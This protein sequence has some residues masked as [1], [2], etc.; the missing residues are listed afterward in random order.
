MTTIVTLKAKPARGIDSLDRA[1][2]RPK[3]I[4][5]RKSCDDDCILA[6]GRQG[7]PP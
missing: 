5:A 2:R 7:L 1:A 3:K 4:T 6:H